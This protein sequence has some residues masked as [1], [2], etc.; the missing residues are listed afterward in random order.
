MG[1]TIKNT[2]LTLSFS[3]ILCNCISYKNQLLEGKANT[4]EARMNVITDFV[5]TYKTP[6]NYIREREGRPFDIFWV[7]ERKIDNNLFAFSVLPENKGYISLRVEDSLGKAPRS[8]LPN[9]YKIREEMLF[10]WN[11]GV[12][13]LQKDILNIMDDYGVLDSIEIK[14]ELGLLPKDCE[15]TRMLIIDDGLKGVDY[16]ICKNNIRKYRKISTSIAFGF[17][18]P[19]ILNCNN[20]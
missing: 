9:R 3:L 4:E 14:R 19:P 2:I 10:L 16:Y 6:R 17:Y 13:P 7:R 5:N 8:Y 15:D 1:K 11:D 18:N 20:H 12:T